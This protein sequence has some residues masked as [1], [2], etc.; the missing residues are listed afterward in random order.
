M[1]WLIKSIFG[2]GGKK[3]E[4]AEEEEEQRRAEEEEAEEDEEETAAR[5]RDGERIY[6]SLSSLPRPDDAAPASEWVLPPSAIPSGW[7]EVSRAVISLHLGLHVQEPLQLKARHAILLLVARN[8][9]DDDNDEE[10]GEREATAEF[11]IIA[12]DKVV[13]RQHLTPAL[14]AVFKQSSRCLD[15]IVS[16]ESG[17]HRVVCSFASISEYSAMRREWSRAAMRYETQM[18]Y[19]KREAK[20]GKEDEEVRYLMKSIDRMQLSDEE[21]KEV[22]AGVDAGVEYEKRGAVNTDDELPESSSIRSSTAASSSS[23]SAA[24]KGHIDNDLLAVGQ[25]LNRTFVNRGSQLGVFKHDIDGNLQYLNQVPVVKDLSGSALDPHHMQLY[26]GDEKMLLLN[27]ANRKDLYEFDLETGAVVQEYDGGDSISVVRT[28][29]PASKYGSRSGEATLVGVNSN[30]VFTLDPRQ[31][32]RNKLA[33]SKAYM[34]KT[35]FRCVATTADGMV[36]VGSDDGSIKLYDSIGKVAKTNLPGLGDPI[37]GI[38][39][40][41]DGS[42]VLATTEH[43]LL[44]IPTSVEAQEKDGFHKSITHS[45]LPIKLLLLPED[46]LRLGIRELHFTPARF[47][48][49][50]GG[51]RLISTSTGPFIVTWSFNAIRAGKRFHYSVRR[52]DATVKTESWVYNQDDMVCLQPSNVFMQR[53]AEKGKRQ[54]KSL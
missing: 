39:V 4:E 6:I 32:G 13:I 24:R 43:Y 18:E 35:S 9:D 47:D 11:R 5:D 40:T 34:G 22:E 48:I 29:T 38:D 3:V 10:D 15:L 28:L 1:S 26:S 19:R 17:L 7:H 2:M 50:E 31:H 30:N 41:A 52:T 14:T 46:M 23:S 42:Y 27:K 25:K 51:E 36:A 8:A 54:T 53:V 16:S 49:G 12:A 20:K 45:V 44:V 33:Q 37:I 21:E